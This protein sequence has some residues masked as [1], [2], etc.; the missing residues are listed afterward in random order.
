MQTPGRSTKRSKNG[1][2]GVAA[3]LACFVTAG[4]AAAQP[5]GAPLAA[6]GPCA[7]PRAELRAAPDALPLAPQSADFAVSGSPRHHFT[8]Q[9]VAAPGAEGGGAPPAPPGFARGP[10]DAPNSG[11]GSILEDAARGIKESSAQPGL[12]PGSDQR[13]TR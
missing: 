7:E 9:D 4:A 10:C 13:D 11:C 2:R 12:P 1:A 5:P 3:A 6:P 8:P